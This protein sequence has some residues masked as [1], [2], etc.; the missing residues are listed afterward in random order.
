[1]RELEFGKVQGRRR[2]GG[3]DIYD[4]YV[5][6]IRRKRKAVCALNCLS[7]YKF[8]GDAEGG[9]DREKYRKVFR[10]PAAVLIVQW[11]NI[12][13]YTRRHVIETNR[14][15]MIPAGTLERP[16][17]GKSERKDTFSFFVWN[18]L[19]VIK[20][21]RDM[22]SDLEREPLVIAV[23]TY[24]CDNEKWFCDRLNTM[25]KPKRGHFCREK[26][27]IYIELND[28]HRSEYNN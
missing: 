2:R 20:R 18:V 11:V 6:T 25:V 26:R 1:M 27:H 23:T 17:N 28:S 7:K 15:E 8:D 22:P 16:R 19:L 3:C 24:I 4:L 10:K 5:N 21:P 13:I 14:V 12:F 9:L